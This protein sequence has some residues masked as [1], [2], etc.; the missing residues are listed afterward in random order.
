MSRTRTVGGRGTAGSRPRDGRS[1]AA[2]LL[3]LGAALLVLGLANVGG[4]GLMVTGIVLLALGAVVL[5]S[6]RRVPPGSTGRRGRLGSDDAGAGAF[7]SWSSGDGWDGHDRGTDGG[8]YD[9]G[10]YDGGGYDGG[11]SDGGGGGGGD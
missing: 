9:G 3:A 7:W 8:G 6:S 10:G 11:G 1:A 5:G 2:L 4:F